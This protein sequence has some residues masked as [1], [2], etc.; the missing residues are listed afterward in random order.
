MTTAASIGCAL[1]PLFR[2]RKIRATNVTLPVEL[3]LDIVRLAAASDS[4][5]ARLL[6]LVCRII[7]SEVDRYRFRVLR[8]RNPREGPASVIELAARRGRWFLV[9]YLQA[10]Y[11]DWSCGSVSWSNWSG[12]RRCVQWIRSSPAELRI[13]TLALNVEVVVE[14]AGMVDPLVSA[15]GYAKHHPASRRIYTPIHPP[16]QENRHAAS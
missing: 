8:W 14:F 12:V 10:L 6:A 15:L 1:A 7:H 11:W 16:S 4:R 3:V 5:V 2:A 9:E 13:S